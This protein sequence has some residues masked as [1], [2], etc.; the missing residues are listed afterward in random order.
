MRAYKGFEVKI[1]ALPS[2]LKTGK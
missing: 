2:A 1:H